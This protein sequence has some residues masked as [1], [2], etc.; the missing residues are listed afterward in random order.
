MRYK[1]KTNKTW[2]KS[3]FLKNL[4]V[5]FQN[6]LC[7]LWGPPNSKLSESFRS[8][9]DSKSDFKKKLKR[10]APFRYTR[11]EKWKLHSFRDHFTS[12]ECGDILINNWGCGICDYLWKAAKDDQHALLAI[13]NTREYKTSYKV[14]LTEC[15]GR[16]I[17]NSH[18]LVLSLNKEQVDCYDF[19]KKPSLTIIKPKWK[20]IS[21][22]VQQKFGIK[23]NKKQIQTL[24]VRYSRNS[25]PKYDAFIATRAAL[26]TKCSIPKEKK[27]KLRKKLFCSSYV[28]NLWK[29]SLHSVLAEKKIGEKEINKFLNIVFPINDKWCTPWYLKKMLMKNQAYWTVIDRNYYI[30][31]MDDQC[32]TISYYKNNWLPRAILNYII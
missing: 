25:K 29:Y 30:D 18:H 14:V 4:N 27:M 22:L 21:H 19:K 16:K 26:S 5:M 11:N 13:S 31:N 12:I 32:F 28:T 8:N 20:E 24:L 1:T 10:Q 6:L 2:Q 23:L 15:V 17:C 9:L 7:L 3:M